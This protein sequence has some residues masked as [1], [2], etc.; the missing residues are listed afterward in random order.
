MSTKGLCTGRKAIGWISLGIALATLVWAATGCTGHRDTWRSSVPTHVPP[1]PLFVAARFGATSTAIGN[2]FLPMTPGS[3]MVFEGDTEDGHERNEVTITSGTK[4]ILGVTCVVVDDRVFVDGELVE[5]TTDWYAQDLDGNVWYMGE[6]SKEMAGGVVVS[7]EGS[8]EAGVDGAQPGFVM[9]ATS[10][11]G[12]VYRQEFYKGEAED[13]A[14]VTAVDETVTLAD[15]TVY[16]GCL[17]IREWTPLDPTV[18]EFK[19]Y[20]PLTGVVLETLEDGSE[21]IERTEISAV[22]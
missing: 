21:P 2:S 4:V 1:P 3:R 8:W 9:E 13:M 22:P 14:E 12:D 7:T 15:G 18:V 6:D 5:Q 10:A 19:Y 17:K 20:A 16:A 11:A